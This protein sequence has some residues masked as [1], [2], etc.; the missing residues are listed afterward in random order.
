MNLMQMDGDDYID[1]VD[2]IDF[3]ADF[4]LCQYG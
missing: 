2:E 3:V 1:V 4:V